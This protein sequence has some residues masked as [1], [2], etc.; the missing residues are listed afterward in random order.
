MALIGFCSILKALL[1][2]VFFSPIM[3]SSLG[4]SKRTLGWFKIIWMIN[5]RVYCTLIR[6]NLGSWNIKRPPIVSRFI[7]EAKYHMALLSTFEF[8][9][10][11]CTRWAD[12]FHLLMISCSTVVTWPVSSLLQ[13]IICCLSLTDWVQ[14]VGILVSRNSCFRWYD[15]RF[16]LAGNLT[17]PTPLYGLGTW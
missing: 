12:T 10:W 3:W 9:G 16:T 5:Y 8:W 7:A 1:V 4:W 15:E 13:T 17:Q 14:R 6:R 2:V 11:K